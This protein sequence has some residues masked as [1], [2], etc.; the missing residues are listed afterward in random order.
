MFSLFQKKLVPTG[1]CKTVSDVTVTDISVRSRGHT[2]TMGTAYGLS[3]LIHPYGDGKDL[4]R[5]LHLTGAS[6]GKKFRVT[7]EELEE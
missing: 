2:I 5:D 6:I 3:V 4:T 7:I 1:S